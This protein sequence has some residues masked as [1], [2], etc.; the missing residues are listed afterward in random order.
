MKGIRIT[1]LEN[2]ELIHEE[3]Y[4]LSSKAEALK[5]FKEK[6]PEFRKGFKILAKNY[7]TEKCKMHFEMCRRCGAVFFY[8]TY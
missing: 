6:H 2:K 8:N 4:I 5:R 1:V 7:D 3:I